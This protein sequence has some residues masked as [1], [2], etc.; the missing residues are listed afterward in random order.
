MTGFV[1]DA[2]LVRLVADNPVAAGLVE[3]I[4]ES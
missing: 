3:K 2:P 4:Y 1:E